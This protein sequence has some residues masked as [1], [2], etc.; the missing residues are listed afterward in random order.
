MKYNKIFI[1]LLSVVLGFIVGALVLKLSHISP[2]DAY[3]IMF[4]GTFERPQYIAYVIIRST[5]L[6]LTGLSVA[7]AF[8]TGLFNIGSEGQFII[9]ALTATVI[10]LKCNLNP[11]F[12]IPLVMVM[13]TISAGIYGGIAGIMKAK[14]GVHEVI[15]TIMLNWIA[16]YLSNYMV[17]S[18]IIHRPDTETSEFI[19]PSGS[20][21]LFENFKN[22]EVGLKYLE[23]HPILAEFLRPPVNAG[24]FFA[25]FAVIINLVYFK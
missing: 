5:P 1:S 24:I 12:Q 25:I 21:T 3:T 13:A 10:G 14:Y 23:S 6:I 8:R 11:F 2:V 18:N 9:G 19:N 15:S 4:K 22:S 17:M 20:I 7:F 16:L